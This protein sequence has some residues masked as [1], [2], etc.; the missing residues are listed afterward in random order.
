MQQVFID[1]LNSVLLSWRRTCPFYIFSGGLSID[2]QG[3]GN[4]SCQ[5]L[6]YILM[7]YSDD[8]RS[9]AVATCFFWAAVLSVTFPR[10]LSALGSVGAFG[11]YAGLNVIAFVMIF[12]LVPGKSP[13]KRTSRRNI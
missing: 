7:Q 1:L 12:L 5:G 10:L 11:F 2:A 3:N 8:F 9:W 4:V 6:V 13:T